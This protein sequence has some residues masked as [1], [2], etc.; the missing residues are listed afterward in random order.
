MDCSAG[1]YL[2]DFHVLIVTERAGETV[3]R[4]ARMDVVKLSRLA[5]V[6]RQDVAGYSVLEM[7][8]HWPN[9]SADVR[10]VSVAGHAEERCSEESP[11]RGFVVV[12]ASVNLAASQDPDEVMC[13]CYPP[14]AVVVSMVLQNWFGILDC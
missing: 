11:G 8:S 9:H 3:E 2:P 4:R 13:P 7:D 5:E 6:R 10:K 14:S 12:F 1:V